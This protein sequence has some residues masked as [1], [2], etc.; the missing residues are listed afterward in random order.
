M[1]RFKGPI[2]FIGSLGNLRSYWDEDTQQQILSLKRGKNPDNYQDDIVDALNQEFKAA[3]IW[4]TLIRRSTLDLVYLKK[5]RLNGKLVKIAKQ[6][7]TLDPEGI[8]G[9]RK[10]ESSKLNAPLVG[11]CMNNAHPFKEVCNIDPEI[12]I[13][14]DR[15]EVTFKLSN[16]VSIGKFKWDVKVHYFRIYVL[17]YELPDIEWDKTYKKYSPVY[18]TDSLGGKTVVSEWRTVSN[19]PENI[20]IP[21]AF[22]DHHLPKEKSTVMVSVGVEF[23]S[24]MLYNTP[25][26]VKG[27]GTCAI[28]GCF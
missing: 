25:Y 8:L 1:A 12:T 20:V 24:A 22:E 15:S 26:V 2:Q 3:N 17:I 16:F 18:S 13:T 21:V 11:F 10:I 23:A 5:G 6:I 14:E 4:S 28:L 9:F 19:L 7:Q 27:N